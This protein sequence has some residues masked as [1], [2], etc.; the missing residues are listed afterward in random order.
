MSTLDRCCFEN[1]FALFSWGFL[2]NTEIAFLRLSF[3]LE[4]LALILGFSAADVK[5]KYT[6]QK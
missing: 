4:F 6:K 2:I 3:F 5:K 1:L